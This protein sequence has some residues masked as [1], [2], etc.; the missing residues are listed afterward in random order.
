MKSSVV[1]QNDFY[2]LLFPTKRHVSDPLANTKF[3]GYKKSHLFFI[4]Q[5]SSSMHCLISK[6]V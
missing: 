6:D 3:V 1:V 4:P 2:M 5:S